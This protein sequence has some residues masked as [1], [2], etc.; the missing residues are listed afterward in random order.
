MEKLSE[1]PDLPVPPVTF[2]WPQWI[3]DL[4]LDDNR[5]FQAALILA[6]TLMLLTLVRIFLKWLISK[7]DT[8]ML[9]T[10]IATTI[11][12]ILCWMSLVG[13]QLA[14]DRIPF[15]KATNKMIAHGFSLAAIFIGGWLVI[16]VMSGVKHRLLGR[17]ALINTD[18]RS[19]KMHTQFTVLGRVLYFLVGLVTLALML[20]TFHGVAGIGTSLLASAGV[21]TL[22]IG[23]AAQKTL[24]ILVS[25]IHIAITQPIRL[26]D[27]V[28]VEGEWGWIEE[29]NFTYVVVR[30]WDLRRLVV[31][32]SYFIEKPFQNWTR[33]STEIIG[34][35]ELRVDYR[36]PVEELRQAFYAILKESPLWN[37]NV[38]A[39]QVT[40][41]TERTMTVR[42]LMTGHD[43]PSTFDLRC[44]MREKMLTWIEAHYPHYLPRTRILY[45]DEAESSELPLNSADPRT[46]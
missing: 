11:T 14:V 26:E 22:I 20:R 37:G 18:F 36:L 27:S 32:I 41:I 38:K 44:E 25:G 17:Y 24:G 46:G 16:A 15:S 21:T 28:V 12:P 6:G 23:F 35:V 4:G 29:I 45:K 3:I 39:V 13:L 34:S 7:Q 42:A 5:L 40:D 1:L 43:A 2:V 9:G 10:V 8:G 30:C 19:R 31:P 33:H